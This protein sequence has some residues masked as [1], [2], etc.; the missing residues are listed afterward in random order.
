MLKFRIM[1]DDNKKMTLHIQELEQ[2]IQLISKS[3][4]TLANNYRNTYKDYQICKSITNQVEKLLG[5]KI[6]NEKNVLNAREELSTLMLGAS[7]PQKQESEKLNKLVS[8]IFK[9][10]PFQQQRS[11]SP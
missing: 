7:E 1:Q 9:E 3:N 8:N 5:R 2:R 6:V 4:Q 11:L 10:R